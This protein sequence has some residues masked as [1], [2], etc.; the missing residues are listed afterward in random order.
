[1]CDSGRRARRRGSV[2]VLVMTLLS[3]LF[4]MGVAFLATMNFEAE[5]L[6]VESRQR[7]STGGIDTVAD[8]SGQLLQEVLMSD[9]IAADRWRSFKPLSE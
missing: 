2:L 9:G 5:R 1:M 3:I 6:M 7:Q 4:V 8:N